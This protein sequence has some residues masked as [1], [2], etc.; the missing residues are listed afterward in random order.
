MCE[1]QEKLSVTENFVRTETQE[2][3]ECLKR[4]FPRW[5]KMVLRPRV[6]GKSVA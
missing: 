4:S 2:I 1:R 6:S 5:R 3:S